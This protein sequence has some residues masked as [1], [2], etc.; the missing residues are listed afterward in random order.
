M[1]KVPVA[2]KILGETNTETAVTIID[3]L[4]ATS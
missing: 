1:F 2:I 3:K 4:K